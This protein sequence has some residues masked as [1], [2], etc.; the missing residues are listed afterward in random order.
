MGLAGMQLMFVKN[1]W[2]DE[3]LTTELT[4]MG[5]TYTGN[6]TQFDLEIRVL[7]LSYSQNQLTFT[8]LNK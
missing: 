8:F 3:R 4:Y 5:C 6:F 1:K 2:V 7:M